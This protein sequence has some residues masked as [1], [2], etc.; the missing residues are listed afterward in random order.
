MSGDS[1]YDV[2]GVGGAPLPVCGA[3]PAREVRERER[4]RLVVTEM[5]DI[6]FSGDCSDVYSQDSDNCDG[7]CGVCFNGNGRE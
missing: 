1:Q 6:Y 5:R 4:F 2:Q 3:G 7:G